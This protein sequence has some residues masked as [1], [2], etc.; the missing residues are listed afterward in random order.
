[1]IRKPRIVLVCLCLFT[2]IFTA[3]AM[4]WNFLQAA[5]TND[6][7]ENLLIPTSPQGKAITKVKPQPIVKCRPPFGFQQGVQAM[8]APALPPVLPGVKLR[9]W[10]L[11]AQ[12]L[13]ARTR[14]K[15]IF[16]NNNYSFAWNAQPEVDFNTA[17][18]IP[19]HTVI[20]SFIAKYRF[21]PRWSVKSL[22]NAY[23]HQWRWW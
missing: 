8:A 12:A 18:G 17:L 22:H 23:N 2:L 11:D 9:G 3:H 6:A 10:D 7:R 19:D 15:A 16:W 5:A 4:A 13:F 1:M 14:G 20:G 21:Q